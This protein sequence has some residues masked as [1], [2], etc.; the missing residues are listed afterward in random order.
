MQAGGL[1]AIRRCAS[2]IFL[3]RAGATVARGGIKHSRGEQG[4]QRCRGAPRQPRAP[5][6]SGNSH[7]IDLFPDLLPGLERGRANFLQSRLAG[8][9]PCCAPTNYPSHSGARFFQVAPLSMV[10]Y[11]PCAGETVACRASTANTDAKSSTMGGRT[12]TQWLPPSVVRK[13]VPARPTTQHT[14][15][16][17]AEPASK[18]VMTP[19]VCRVQVA[20][21]SAECSMMP[22]VPIRHCIALPGAAMVTALTL[23]AKTMACFSRKRDIPDISCFCCNAAGAGGLPATGFGLGGA[24]PGAA[25]ANASVLVETSSPGAGVTDGEGES[26]A[27]FSLNS[28]APAARLSPTSDFARVPA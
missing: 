17:G 26:A 18:S 21:L 23:L 13:I 10:W 11:V 14:L 28:L 19:L 5:S 22:A 3:L 4:K 9:Q 16:E 7:R 1:I 6:G 12:F 25:S 24:E 8:A 15:S 2:G 20:P 27:A